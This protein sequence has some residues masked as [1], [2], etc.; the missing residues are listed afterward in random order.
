MVTAVTVPGPRLMVAAAFWS[1]TVA[2]NVTAVAPLA[3]AGGV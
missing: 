2:V 1:V 3:V